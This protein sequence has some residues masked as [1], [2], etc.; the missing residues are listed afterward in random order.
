MREDW[1]GVS[2]IH[3]FRQNILARENNPQVHSLPTSNNSHV[4]CTQC[5]FYTFTARNRSRL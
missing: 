4:H 3:F 5:I 1:F 2:E